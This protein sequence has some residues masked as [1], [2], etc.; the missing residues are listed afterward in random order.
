[1]RLC[2]ARGN[3]VVRPEHKFGVT[4]VEELPREPVVTVAVPEAPNALVPPFVAHRDVQ[5]VSEPILEEELQAVEQ[6]RMVPIDED[7]HFA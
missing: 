7:V 1:M 6:A 2:L 4:Q 3:R 5:V